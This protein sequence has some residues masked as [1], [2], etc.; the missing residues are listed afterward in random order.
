MTAS[1]RDRGPRL[2]R[3]RFDGPA[4]AIAFCSERLHQLFVVARE[5][6]DYPNRPPSTDVRRY[7][8]VLV[9]RRLVAGEVERRG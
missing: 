7:F 9:D 1:S 3:V 4:E 5:S 8:D 2:V 6:G